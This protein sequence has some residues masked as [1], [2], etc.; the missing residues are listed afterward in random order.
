MDMLET[1]ASIEMPR[2]RS[3]EKVWALKLASAEVL[4]DGSVKIVPADHH[5]DA[6]TQSPEWGTRFKGGETDDPGYLVIY[7]SGYESWFPTRAFE[8]EYTAYGQAN[9]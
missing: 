1:M 4:A 8:D 6:M 7:S 2:Y 5:Y 9:Y 3:N